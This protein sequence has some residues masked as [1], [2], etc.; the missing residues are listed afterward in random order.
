MGMRT[1]FAHCRNTTTAMSASTK[2][3]WLRTLPEVCE[4]VGSVVPV[5]AA[6]AC[7]G[8]SGDLAIDFQ[9]TVASAVTLDHDRTE[10]SGRRSV[11]PLPVFPRGGA[12]RGAWGRVAGEDR[13]EGPRR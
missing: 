13:R 10:R 4:A 5:G 1:A 8:G 3:A 2:V 12:V 6:S 11:Y 9:R 7:M